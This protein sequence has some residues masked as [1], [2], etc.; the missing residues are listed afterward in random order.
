VTLSDPGGDPAS[1]GRLQVGRCGAAAN[2][3]LYV[4]AS[5]H[6]AELEVTATTG[7]HRDGQS[8]LLLA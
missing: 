5:F 6:I 1:D 7:C 2:G 8:A 3:V 4:R